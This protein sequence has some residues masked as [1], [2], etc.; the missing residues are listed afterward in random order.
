MSTP[1][2]I[3]R[4]ARDIERVGQRSR[5]LGSLQKAR[6]TLVERRDELNSEIARYDG[7]IAQALE[8]V[9]DIKD[10]LLTRYDADRV[11]SL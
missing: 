2:E 9:K 7:L 5:T 11:R 10:R 1:A 6:D 3:T 8:Q 4:D